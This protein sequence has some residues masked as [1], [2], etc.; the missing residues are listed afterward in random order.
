MEVK[1]SGARTDE[2]SAGNEQEGGEFCALAPPIV[3][4]PGFDHQSHTKPVHRVITSHKIRQ[5]THP[6]KSDIG[7]NHIDKFMARNDSGN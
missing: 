6:N 3:D 5:P 1:Y 4:T 2:T 7:D